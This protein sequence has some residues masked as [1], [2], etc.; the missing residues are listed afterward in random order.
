MQVLQPNEENL[1]VLIRW[2]RSF[3]LQFLG[4]RHLEQ[5]CTEMHAHFPDSSIEIEVITADRLRYSI[6]QWSVFKSLI[7]DALQT[8]PDRPA[9]CSTEYVIKRF[10]DEVGEDRDGYRRSLAFINLFKELIDYEKRGLSSNLLVALII[11]CE[12]ALVALALFREVFRDSHEF[13]A[14]VRY[15]MLLQDRLITHIVCRHWIPL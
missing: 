9:N 11:H 4:K 15:V 6:P 10:E 7:N 13:S 14:T 8:C 1:Q 12:A 5:K 2:I 3:L